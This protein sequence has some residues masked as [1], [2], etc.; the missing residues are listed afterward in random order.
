MQAFSRESLEAFAAGDKERM[1]ARVLAYFRGRGER[2]ATD[3]EISKDFEVPH[4][5]VAPRRTR[6]EDEGLIVKLLDSD[7]QRVRRKT[8]QGCYAGVYVAAEFA[9]SPPAYP[10][11]D[12]R[13]NHQPTIVHESPCSTPRLDQSAGTDRL[14]PDD[15]PRRHLA[16]V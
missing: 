6:L 16:L 7:G 15:A 11:I 3:D 4:N 12:P 2:G 8:R 1:R 9:T 10:Q 13:A 14:F 5:S